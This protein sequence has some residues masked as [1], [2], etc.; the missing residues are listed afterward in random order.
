LIAKATAHVLSCLQRTVTLAIIW[1]NFADEM[2]PA[3]L[4]HAA[5]IVL[6]NMLALGRTIPAAELPEGQ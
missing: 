5:L 2:K 4:A 6:A 3:M 1:A